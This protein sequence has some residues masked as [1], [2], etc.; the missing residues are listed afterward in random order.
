MRAAVSA[1]PANESAALR[2]FYHT[3]PGRLLLRPL[4]CQ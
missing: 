3:A 4:I 1:A 2:F